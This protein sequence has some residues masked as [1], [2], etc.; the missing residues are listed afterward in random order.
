QTN[1]R[2]N[3]VPM[4]FTSDLLLNE[5]L[6]TGGLTQNGGETSLNSCIDAFGCLYEH[7]AAVFEPSAV[8]H[9]RYCNMRS[10][11]EAGCLTGC[12]AACGGELQNP[13]GC[14]VVL[15]FNYRGRGSAIP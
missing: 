9:A 1:G 7:P 8:I 15:L 5:I 6:V 10:T 12:A 14:L 3:N 11:T 2:A 4:I 13:R